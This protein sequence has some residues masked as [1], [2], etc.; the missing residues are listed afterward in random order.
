MQKITD[1]ISFEGLENDNYEFKVK[2]ESSDDKVEKWA[3]TIVGFANSYSGYILVGVTDDGYVAGLNKKEIDET[4]NLI[5]LVINRKIFPHVHPK[6]KIS[7]CENDKYVLSVFIDCSN[8]M[9]I[10]K[11]GDF[12]EKVYVRENGSTI[13][14]SISQIVKLS[15]KKFGIDAQFINKQ[16][17]KKDF[18]LFNKLAKEYRIDKK[19]PTEKMLINNE[20]I[21]QD[22][23]ITQG[24]E[25]FSDYYNEDDTL[26]SC[27]LWNGFD[28]G[29]DEVI[30]KKEFKG[31]IS[32]TFT[33]TM[34]FIERNSRSGFIKM[35]NGAR[36]D[37]Y[38]YPE[39]ALREAI[40]NA[41]AHRDYSINGTQIDIDI[42]KDRL[43]ITSPGSWLLSKEPEEYELNSIPSIR[44]N[45]II[46]NCFEVIG[47]MEKSGS[48]LKKI[49]ETYKNFNVKMP[50]LYNSPDFFTI[51][52]YDLLNQDEAIS[53]EIGPYDI[54]I[55]K[56]CDGVARSRKEIQSFLG[57]KSTSNFTRNIL[58]P[59]V[60]SGLLT[61]TAKRFS[62][63]Q[64]YLTRK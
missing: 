40:V 47:L 53:K 25:M 39:I 37:T 30:D 22:G 31:S 46:C 11:T 12:N 24:L 33:E 32:N 8:E 9:V 3:K 35:E 13:P 44:R 41:I 58:T 38:S 1:L 61:P 23:R 4:K 64:K 21:N 59:L 56:Y 34:N 42:F 2:L 10:F 17:E 15:K 36:L 49:Y 54:K 51:T 28:K 57:F 50:V 60:E 62:K 55:L 20:V 5:L 29:V 14:A 26:I 6:F 48:G 43:E 45:K 63:N 7:K 18:T 16:Y 52:F 27:R 19:E